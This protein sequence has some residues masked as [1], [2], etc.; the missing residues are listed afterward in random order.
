MSETVN[1]CQAP[2]LFCEMSEK[3]K[4]IDPAGLRNE[5]SSDQEMDTHDLPG[6]QSELRGQKNK[7]VHNVSTSEEE[8]EEGEDAAAAAA[9]GPSAA[10]ADPKTNS[11]DANLGFRIVDIEMTG[12]GSGLFV[13]PGQKS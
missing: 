1:Q 13:Q 5:E 4:Q 8:E 3:I 10:A 12:S 9:K 6:S 11:A 2:V 7:T